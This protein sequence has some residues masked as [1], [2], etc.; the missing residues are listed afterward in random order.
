MG[1][2]HRFRDAVEHGWPRPL[3]LVEHSHAGLANAYVAGASGCRSGCCAAT[4]APTSRAQRRRHLHRLPVHRRAAH[5]RAGANPDVDVIHAQQA[6]RQGNV[7]LWGLSGCRRRPCSPPSARSSPSRR[8]STSS[9]APHA[10]VLPHWVV[11]AVCHVP[12]GAWPSYAAGYSVRDNAFYSDWDEI[13]RDRDR[14]TAGWRRTCCRTRRRAPSDG[15]ERRRP[16]R[17]GDHDDQRRARAARRRRSASS[18][19]ARPTRPPT[20]PAACTRPT[21]VLVYE[22]G[23]IGAQA[24][25]ACR[26]RSAT[27]TSP[28]PP[29][30]SSRVPEMF[31]YWIGG[32]PHRRRLPRRRADRPLR[33]HQ[34]DRHRRLRRAEGAP[35]RRRR[36]PGDRRASPARSSSCCA[37]RSAR[38]WSELDFITSVGRQRRRGD[39]TARPD[40]RSS[41]T[42]A[43]CARARTTAS[44]SSSRCTPASSSTTS[45]R[46]TGWDLRVREPLEVT[47]PATG[48]EID[49]LRKLR[50]RET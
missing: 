40:R 45:A 13:A 4:P 15:T 9:T 41:P 2:L 12:G 35:A 48:E 25:R 32:G 20:S 5:R 10:V 26:C 19:S 47:E 24:A 50:A 8:S 30:S 36:R 34:H 3:E 29:T 31:N 44:S 22:S 16:R 23:A 46:P 38:S 49:A 33:Q 27:T 42:S 7:M 1:S 6:D 37:T 39:S 14:F 17:R 11:D 28:R 21:C 43:S 18:A